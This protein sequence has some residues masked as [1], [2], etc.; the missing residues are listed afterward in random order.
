MQRGECRTRLL[1]LRI[2]ELQYHVP[3]NALELPWRVFADELEVI[4]Q[5]WFATLLLALVRRNIDLH[6]TDPPLA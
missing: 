3:A 6:L 2:I 5:Q 4:E 1:G